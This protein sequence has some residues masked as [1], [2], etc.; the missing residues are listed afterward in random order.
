MRD[1]FNT[2]LGIVGAFLV[3]WSEDGFGAACTEIRAAIAD[4]AF[5]A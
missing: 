4:G 1:W 2:A 3:I 5:H